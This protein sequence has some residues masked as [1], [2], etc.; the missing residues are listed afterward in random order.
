MD[1]WRDGPDVNLLKGMCPGY[2][3]WL[4]LEK[5]EILDDDLNVSL[6][7]LISHYF[8]DYKS[9]FQESEVSLS[10]HRDPG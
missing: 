6:S 1:N 5:C 10:S 7:T 4:S 8:G 3:A 9:K 2:F